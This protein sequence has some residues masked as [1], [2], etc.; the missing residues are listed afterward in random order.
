MVQSASLSS[1]QSWSSSAEVSS[2]SV[3]SSDFQCCGFGLL[4]LRSGASGKHVLVDALYTARSS[5]MG[6]QEVIHRT[7]PSV[8]RKRQSS[9][10][11][12]RTNESKQLEAALI[13][14][15]TSGL[16]FGLVGRDH[17]RAGRTWE[18]WSDV[19]GISQCQDHGSIACAL[20]SGLL[21][22]EL[23][24]KQPQDFA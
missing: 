6:S 1:F 13:R 18:T 21:K 7:A 12:H 14:P 19:T 3:D 2:T 15:L 24:E 4:P 10:A 11:L 17:R 16:L 20:R 23:K 22:T 8:G 5:S 9:K